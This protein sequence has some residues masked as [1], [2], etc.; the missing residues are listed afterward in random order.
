MFLYSKILKQAYWIVKK[1][2]FLWIFGLFLVWGYLPNLTY[3]HKT[4]PRTIAGGEAWLAAASVVVFVVLILIYFRARA[5]L[6]I[7][8][9]GVLDKQDMNFFKAWNLGK[10]S[11]LKMFQVSLLVQIGLT[12]VFLV[13][14]IPVIY[15]A[16]AGLEPRAV[17]LGLAALLI[18]LPIWFVATMVNIAAQVFIGLYNFRLSGAIAA[19]LDLVLKR[20]RQMFGVAFFMFSLAFLGMILSIVPAGLISLGVVFFGQLSYHNGST[21]P[22]GLNITNLIVSIIVFFFVQ[23]FICVYH[24]VAWVLTILDLTKPPKVEEEKE[25]AEMPEVA[26]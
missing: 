15:L 14:T 22:Y 18:F 12:I 16:T 23:A 19:A 13:L 25:L 5:G 24:Q 17:I 1:H 2:K 9:K 4:G 10:K 3:L 7:A 8:T 20:W 11:Y 21:L 6:I 26:S